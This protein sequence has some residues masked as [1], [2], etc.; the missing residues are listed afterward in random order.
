MYVRLNNNQPKAGDR[1]LIKLLNL[2]DDFALRQQLRELGRFSIGSWST[3]E[4]LHALVTQAVDLR[5]LL[6][7]PVTTSLIGTNQG[8]FEERVSLRLLPNTVMVSGIKPEAAENPSV[9]VL[10]IEHRIMP[11]PVTAQAQLG[12][13]LYRLYLSEHQVRVE[14]LHQ[15][16]LPLDGS[17]AAQE[18][19]LAQMDFHLLD[20][21]AYLNE[22]IFRGTTAAQVV[23]GKPSFPSYINSQAVQLPD[24]AGAGVVVAFGRPRNPKLLHSSELSFV[25]SLGKA[26]VYEHAGESQKLRYVSLL[27]V[28]ALLQ[29]ELAEPHRLQVVSDEKVTALTERHGR[30]LQGQTDYSQW[31]SDVTQLRH[32]NRFLID[33]G[34]A[35]A[36]A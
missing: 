4:K 34:L 29:D 27:D 25:R 36:T 33:Q 6:Q 35:S 32:L 12:P 24:S 28:Q 10:A 31:L 9:G 17:P 15:R 7:V 20:R 21:C 5:Q 22:C 8:K 2:V 3:L 14:T 26:A 30:S 1:E 18:I 16:P 11:G 23:Y 19:L 13:G